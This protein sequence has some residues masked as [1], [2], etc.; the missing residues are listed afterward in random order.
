VISDSI[1]LATAAAWN[2]LFLHDLHP[3]NLLECGSRDGMRLVPAEV[4]ARTDI[5]EADDR[6]GR[7]SLE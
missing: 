7:M 6:V 4:G 3:R 2:V 5:D 1:V